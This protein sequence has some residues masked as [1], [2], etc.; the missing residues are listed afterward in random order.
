MSES[1]VTFKHLPKK[2]LFLFGYH[3]TTNQNNVCRCP[4]SENTFELYSI[5]WIS[6]FYKLPA[7]FF[8]LYVCVCKDTTHSSLCACSEWVSDASEACK[9]CCHMLRRH[10]CMQLLSGCARP[11]HLSQ[12]SFQTERNVSQVKN[13]KNKKKKKQKSCI[14]PLGGREPSMCQQVLKKWK[15]LCLLG[16]EIK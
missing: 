11:V 13:K 8:C 12:S 9:R 14:F 6:Y 16:G 10:S 7:H 15:C 4:E 5:Y 1:D 3:K 2:T